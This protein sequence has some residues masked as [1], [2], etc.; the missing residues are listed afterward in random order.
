MKIAVCISG[1]TRNFNRVLGMSDHRGPMD[2]V[3]ELRKFFPTVDVYGHTWAHC[4]LPKQDPVKFTKLQVDD[5]SMIDDWVSGDFLNRA[6]S[7]RDMWN[8]QNKLSSLG[9]QKFVDIHLQR[10]R[11]AYG[12]V[13]SAFR[14]FELVPRGHYDVVIRY[15]WDLE[16]LGDTD[17]FEKTVVDRIHWLSRR[18]AQDVAAGMSTCNT[19]V[20]TGNPL[21]ITLEDTFFMVNT[22]GHEYL[23]ADSIEHRLSVI[24]EGAWGGEKSEAHTLWNLVI[25]TQMQHKVKPQDKIMFAL[26]L[27]NMFMLIRLP[28]EKMNPFAHLDD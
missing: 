28:G 6:Y 26:H 16:H 25:F 21:A 13:F 27:P 20:Y 19:T 11:A 2:F 23:L 15:R 8:P 5:Q 4:E 22:R 17:H 14:C 10:S 3:N 12:Q 1:E 7:N 24:F 9:P 18:T